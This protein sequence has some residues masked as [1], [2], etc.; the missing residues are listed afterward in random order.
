MLRKANPLYQRHTQEPP[1]RA[2]VG[3]WVTTIR[4]IT[5]VKTAI[6]RRGLMRSQSIR[7]IQ[8]PHTTSTAI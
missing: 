7:A 1:Q 5:I 2:W 3:L 8:P 4:R 6:I